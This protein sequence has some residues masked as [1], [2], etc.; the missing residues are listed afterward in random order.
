MK[1]SWN[2]L[3]EWLPTKLTAT[4]TAALLTDIGLEVESTTP[5]ESI[6]GSL[7]GLIV[8]EV[9]KVDKHPDA[10]RLKIT[11]V[12]TGN[13]NPVQVVCGAPN[14]AVGQRVIYAPVGTTIYPT[15]KESITIKKAKIRG[16]ESEGML[17]AEDEIGLGYAHEGLY[18]LP[19]EY[20]IGTALHNYIPVYSDVIFEI[21]LTA[22]HADAFSHYGIARE[23]QAALQVREI[24]KLNLDKSELE[25]TVKSTGFSYAYPNDIRTLKVGY[26]QKL[27]ETDSG[28]VMP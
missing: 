6:K 2:W 12:N 11:L 28:K 20:T 10:D 14:V 3:R 25:K 16:I 8:A 17:C 18:I 26:F 19:K 7:A 1:I 27:F 13:G 21:G 23:L 24:E 5:F 15:N 4:E 22:N 9:V